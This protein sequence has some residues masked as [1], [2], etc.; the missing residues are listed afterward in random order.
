MIEPESTVVALEI[1]IEAITLTASA[2]DLAEASCLPRASTLTVVVSRA[3]G[4]S[5]A[6]SSAL[7]VGA[8]LFS[9]TVPAAAADIS[10]KLMADALTSDVICD[11]LSAS[12]SIALPVPTTD[13][14]VTLPATTAGVLR[15][16][17]ASVL[18][19]IVLR[20]FAP[21]PAKLP[22]LL[23]D[24]ANATAVDLASIR[25]S[26]VACT[27]MSPSALTSERSISADVVLEI[28]LVAVETPTAS[29]AP[30]TPKEA[31]IDTACTTVSIFEVSEVETVMPPSTSIP[32]PVVLVINAWVCD[33]TRFTELAPAPDSATATLP[34]AMAAE[35]ENTVASMV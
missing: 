6:R 1:P 24:S 28:S 16:I 35:P 33:P 30:N 9:V 26:S 20:A 10:P 4:T 31:A 7:T 11:L 13:K 23:I 19:R 8:R 34:P 27:L 21:P 22:P 17:A 12:T 14:P 29:E 15:S 5:V 3:P 25:A 18:F 32:A 2:A